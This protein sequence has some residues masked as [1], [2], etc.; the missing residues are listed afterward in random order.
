MWLL[1]LKVLTNAASRY[2]QTV[3]VPVFGDSAALLTPT[4]VSWAYLCTCQLELYSIIRINLI[5]SL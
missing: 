2:P 1:V 3:P 5:T 4:N